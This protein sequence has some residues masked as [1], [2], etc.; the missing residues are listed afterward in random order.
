MRILVVDDDETLRFTLS[1]NLRTLGHT[2]YEA[3][4]G[5]DALD[6]LS[7]HT[8]TIDLVF[9]DINMPRLSGLEA[10]VAIKKRKSPCLCVMLTA[11]ADIKDAVYAIKQGAYDYIEK[12][13]D[14]D[15]LKT[16]LQEVENACNLVTQIAF[17]APKLYFKKENTMVGDSSEI[18]KVYDII[19]KLSKVE[20]S[21][22][23]EGESGTGKELVAKAIHFNSKRKKKPFVA[24][25]CGAIPEN[26]IES[27]LFGFEKGSF[28]GATHN[29]M[30]KF[31]QAYGGTLFL[32]EIGDISLQMQVKL[33]RVLQEKVFSP[34]GSLKEIESNVRIIAATNKNLTE[35]IKQEKFRLDLYYRIN[36][37]PIKLPPLRERTEDIPEL[38]MHLIEKFNK[39]FDHQIERA[40]H[41]SLEYLK[42]YPWP[43]NIRELANVIERCF[44]ME[45]SST[46]K[47]NT[48]E[49][50]LRINQKINQE[51]KETEAKVQS[52]HVEPEVKQEKDQNPNLNFQA[53]KEKFEK[54]FLVSALQSNS[55]K[56]NQ[57]AL[58][59]KIPKVTLLR[60]I[61]KY[62]INPKKYH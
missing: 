61:A 33:L 38:V 2:A 60:K 7:Q 29:K 51:R 31:Q 43:G 54:D 18:T 26:L 50:H 53:M 39:T 24:I 23:I 8:G 58:K 56:I 16:L 3:Y 46:I 44:I 41:E 48:L 25:N 11:Y 28:T 52:I 55:G 4:D 1:S 13:I 30:G 45:S 22:L 14:R 36:V 20:S 40:D 27:E 47:K 37:L 59:T 32:D 57:T 5:Q 17:S 19:E 62:A 6:V 12:P 21:V 15:S 34:L 35:L 9:L 10:L 42:S 49:E